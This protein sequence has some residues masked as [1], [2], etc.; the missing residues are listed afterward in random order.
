MKG[1]LCAG[2]R[3]EAQRERIGEFAYVAVHR[4]GDAQAWLT[5]DE[6]RRL[7]VILTKAADE[8]DGKETP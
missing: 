8:A 6:A 1:E 3:V 5:P 2:I 7:A 4:V